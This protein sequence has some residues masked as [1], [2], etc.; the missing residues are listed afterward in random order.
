MKKFLALAI[1]CALFVGCA[2]LT[3]FAQRPAAKASIELLKQ[4]AFSFAAAAAAD[5]VKQLATNG[6]VDASR[7]GMAGGA[8][9]LW[10]AA[11]YIRQLQNTG[12]VLDPQANAA[13]LAAAGLPPD[14]A[15]ALAAAVTANARA[16]AARGVPPDA[17]SEITASAFDAA[18]KAIQ[19]KK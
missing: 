11:A 9:A 16:L 3:Q 7:A 1:L 4:A 10:T 19:E 17:A 13:Q 18:A 12:D 8:A 14:S 2:Q 15:Q 6:K 5:S